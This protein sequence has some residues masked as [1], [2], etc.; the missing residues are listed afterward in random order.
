MMCFTPFPLLFTQS[1][2]LRQMVSTDASDLFEQR[3]DP[4]MHEYTDTS[5]DVSMDDTLVHL[6][7]M[8]RGVKEDR[9][10]IW[11]IEHCQSHKVIGSICIW[12]LNAEERSGELGY[13]ILPA[14]QGKGFMKEALAA[15]LTYGFEKMNLSYLDAYTEAQNIRSQKLLESSG[16]HLIGKLEEP[17]Q[18]NNRVF[19]MMIYRVKNQNLSLL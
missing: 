14:Y 5:P 1:L 13:G 7:K 12:N 16:F 10:I 15:V 11:A 2:F 3:S 9:W 6:E 8:I 18:F 17:S 19:Q 4:R